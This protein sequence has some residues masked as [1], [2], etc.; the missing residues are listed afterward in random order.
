MSFS[1]LISPSSTHIDDGFY[2][3]LCDVIFAHAHIATFIQIR[4]PCKNVEI[5]LFYRQCRT[6][7]GGPEGHVP[8]PPPPHEEAKSALKK[9]HTQKTTFLAHLSRRLTG[10]LIGYP[11]I[12]R[13]LS[14]SVVRPSVHIFKRLLLRNRLAN[15][16]QILCGASLGRGNESLYKWSRSHDQDGHLAHIW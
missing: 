13:P 2:R 16:S 3:T 9:T 11:W 12:Q 15:Q 6:Q 8:P 4:H 1:F 7:G 14:S 5:K 10:E